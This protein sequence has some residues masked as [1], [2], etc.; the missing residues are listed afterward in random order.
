MKNLKRLLAVLV[1]VIL[2]G[3]LTA[4]TK[5]NEITGYFEDQGYVR[6]TYNNKGNSL[7][8][9]LHDALFKDE[10]ENQEVEGGTTQTTGDTT[11]TS[12][13]A[14][15]TSD[16]S[17]LYF[18]FTSYLFSNDDFAVVVMEFDSEELLQEKLETSE[19]IQAHFVLLQLYFDNLLAEGEIEEAIVVNQD[20]YVNGNCLL[21]LISAYASEYEYFIDIFQGNLEPIVVEET[22]TTEAE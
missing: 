10:L 12:G 5:T 22:T 17:D 15:V 16:V 18:G 14:V 6:Y 13:E 19:A 3:G 20:D 4:C 7:T 21:V 1:L 2:A 9:V 11:D 8:F